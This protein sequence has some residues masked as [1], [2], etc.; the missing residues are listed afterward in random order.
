MF[1]ALQSKLDTILRGGGLM[2]LSAVAALAISLLTFP[3][4][5]ADAAEGYTLG[6]G[7]HVRVQVSDFR[8]GGEVYRWTVYETGKDF[9]VGPNGRLSLPIVG[10]LDAEGKTTGELEAEVA[11]KLQAKTGLIARPDASIQI[12]RYRPFYVI[13]GVDKPGEYEYQPGLTVLQAFAMAGGPPRATTDQLI[14]FEK[15]ALTSRGNL[16]VLSVDRISLLARQARLDA[17][18]ADKPE[19]AFPDELR[20]NSAN[21]DVAH[22]LQEEQLQFDSRRSGLAKQVNAVDQNKTYLAGEINALRQKGESL[23]AELAAMRKER[24]IIAGLQSR[25]LSAAP[26]LLE[27]EQS[28]AQIEGDQTDVEVAIV[29]ANEDISKDDRDIAGLKAK[30]RKETLEEA[31]E[32]RDKLAE[33]VKKIQT[34]RNLIQEAEVRAPGIARSNASGYANPI[35]V[36]SRPAKDGKMENFTAQETDAIQ[37]GD[38]LRV[39]PKNADRAMTAAPRLAD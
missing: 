13:G 12:V 29:R 8:S 30:F 2:K 1:V 25:G 5:F 38:V 32:V 37:P 19:L 33:T 9:I 24:E 17:E 14:G 4:S 7:D 39:T 28:I 15:D 34:S 36:L 11:A 26:R 22:V 31:A 35:F 18:I 27:L 20:A 6:P 10:E 23:G 21:P 16:A 3:A